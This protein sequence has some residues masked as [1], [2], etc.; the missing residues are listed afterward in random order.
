MKIAV[1]GASGKLGRLVIEKL[2]AKGAKDQVVALVRTPEKAADLGV[3]VRQFDYNEPSVD[4]LAG[5]DKLLLI[6]G[7]E[8]GQRGRQHA[9][10]IEAAKKAG[11]KEI[12]YT[13]LLKADTSGISLAVEH[14]ETEIALKNSG[15]SFTI[16]RNGWYTENYTDGAA[17]NV[18]S[19]AIIGSTGDGKISSAPRADY[20]EAAAVVLTTGGHTGKIYE[21]AGD[22]AYTLS[23]LAAEISKQAAKPVTFNNVPVAEYAAFLV[24]LNLPEPIATMIAGWDEGIAKNDLYFE[25]HDLSQLIGRP[26]TPVAEVLAAALKA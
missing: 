22:S 3:E 1:T 4:A 9:N 25:G 12:V 7:S 17:N 26:T 13:S 5:I 21:L 6:S 19:G 15:L 10:V 11:V 2:I 20:A 14:L 24:S 16:L 18:A 8:L 23:E